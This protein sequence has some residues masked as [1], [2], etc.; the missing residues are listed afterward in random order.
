MLSDLIYRLRSLFRRSQVEAELDDELRY[1]LDRHAE[2]LRQ[3]GL[4]PEEAMR[5]ARLRFGGPEQR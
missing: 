1:H 5:Q 3:S 4:P 2:Q